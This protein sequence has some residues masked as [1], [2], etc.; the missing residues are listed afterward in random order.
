MNLI[1]AL[2]LIFFIFLLGIIPFILL[3]LFSDLMYIIL[4]RIFGY[5]KKVIHENLSLSFPDLEKKE[6]SKLM[7]RAFKNLADIIIEGIKGFT[8]THGQIRRRHKVLNPEI[9]EPFTREGKSIIALP[10][11]YGNWEWGALSPGLFIK[12]YNIVG[13]YKPLTNRYVDR[14]I[15]KNRSRTGTTLASIYKTARTF[16][17]LKDT[18]TIFI[19]AADQ[20]PSNSKKS[21]WIDF[22]GRDTA[23]LHGPEDYARKYD[24]PLVYTEIQRVKRGYYELN[25]TILADKPCELEKGEITK[26]YA[27]ALEKQ[28]LN[29]PENWLWSH[30][31]WKLNR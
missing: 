18:P 5:R 11:H 21:Y 30:R 20:S 2:I 28:I 7:S 16:E 8:M 23:F 27:K 25:L 12:D 15:R 26:R 31:R 4:Y 22:L 17:H 1:L 19:M 10:T 24:I 14:F 6:L 13:F 9:V 29:K 3:Y